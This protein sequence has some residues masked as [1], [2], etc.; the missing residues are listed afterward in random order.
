MVLLPEFIGGRKPLAAGV[1]CIS[2]VA[3]ANKHPWIFWE[4]PARGTDY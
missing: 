3:V 4:L 2:S 1:P